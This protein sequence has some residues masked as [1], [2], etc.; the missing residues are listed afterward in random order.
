MKKIILFVMVFFGI[1]PLMHNGKVSFVNIAQVHAEDFGQEEDCDPTDIFGDC[2]CDPSDPTGDCYCNPDDPMSD[3]YCDPTDPNGNCYCDPTDPFSDCYCDS[4]DPNSSC[5]D[6]TNASADFFASTNG[7]AVNINAGI[8]DLGS[9]DVAKRNYRYSWVFYKSTLPI[10]YFQWYFTSTEKG[11]HKYVT[12][13]WEFETLE[14]Q[15]QARTGTVLGG[16]FTLNMISAIPTVGT[17][18]AIMEL[19]FTTTASFVCSGSPISIDS[20]P[21]TARGLWNVTDPPSH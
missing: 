17:Y 9:T 20:Q 16:T 19:N 1:L 10:P 21:I 4:T 15:G 11:V 3:C 5:Y 13:H 8:E 14:H 6:C 2:Y 7:S 12:D 18:N